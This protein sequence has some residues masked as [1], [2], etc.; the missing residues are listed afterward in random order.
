M[1][2]LFNNMVETIGHTPMVRINKI[3][4]GLPGQVLAKLESFNPLG[5]VKERIAAAMIEA[6]E[7]SGQINSD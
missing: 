6:G 7:K 3:N 4:E 2:R 5:S 1:S